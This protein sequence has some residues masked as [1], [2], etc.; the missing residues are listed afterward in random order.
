SPALK[1]PLPAPPPP[2]E[3]QAREPTQDPFPT[4][5][6]PTPETAEP[7]REQALLPTH[8]PSPAMK[9]PTL[10]ALSPEPA[11]RQALNPSL[12]EPAPTLKLPAPSPSAPAPSQAELPLQDPG[13]AGS[14]PALILAPSPRLLHALAWLQLLGPM[15]T[16]SP[17]SAKLQKVPKSTSPG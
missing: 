7:A 3:A 14:P 16:S 15:T 1:V 8:E 11:R 4:L 10:P 5:K 12:H 13:R 17:L 6:L 9:L 2:P